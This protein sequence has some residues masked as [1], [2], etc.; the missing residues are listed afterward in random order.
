MIPI[1]IVQTPVCDGLGL[2][3]EVVG[4][5]ARMLIRQITAGR[6]AHRHR[7]RIATIPPGY[8]SG[9]VSA[10]LAPRTPRCVRWRAS[11]IR[12]LMSVRLPP[13]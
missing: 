9:R 5:R 3:G 4:K 1:V 12:L 11:T 6:A 2:D 10:F 8:S 7:S 13:T